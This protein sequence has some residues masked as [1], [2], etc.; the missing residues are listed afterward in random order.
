MTLFLLAMTGAVAAFGVTAVATVVVRKAALRWAWMDRPDGYRKLHQ[1]VTPSAGGI[2][3]FVGAAVGTVV[4]LW[5]AG[6][7]GLGG[8]ALH[9]VA[10]VGALAM[11]AVGAYDDVRG[12]GF[13]P[14]FAVE[15]VVAYALLHAGYRIDLSALP[16]IG[17]DVYLEALYSIPLT[18]LWVVGVINA[19]NLIDG[20]DGLASGVVAIAFASMALAFGIRGD[21][22]LVLVAVVFVG[23]LV[24]FLVHN[25]NP[26]SIF[27]GDS[28]SLFL[29]YVLA[30]YTLSSPANSDPALAP[31]VPLLALGLPL[32]DTS[33]SMAR[34]VVERRQM[35]APDRD[36]I[37]HRMTELM[38]VRKAVAVLYVVSA[39]FGLLA[40]VASSAGG[41]GVALTVAAGGAL[42]AGLIVRLGYVRLPYSRPEIVEVTPPESPRVS[43]P[44]VTDRPTDRPTGRSGAERVEDLAP[45]YG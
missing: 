43:P 22:P 7:V 11:V 37:H 21:L 36:H 5:A 3:I 35:F 19:V 20:I 18:V 33:L 9:P 28:G 1:T 8:A 14:K 17:S 32:L 13:K 15:I 12:L 29:G 34:R 2:A 4:V 31:V 38:P 45:H 42:A 40:V 39:G 23:A 6:Q 10:Y 27:M 41:M 30:V 16:F 44:G 24:G 25:F 26:A